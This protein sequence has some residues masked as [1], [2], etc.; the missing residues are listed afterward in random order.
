MEV[1]S[2]GV[3]L[4]PEG[5]SEGSVYKRIIAEGP[6]DDKPHFYDE[7]LIHYTGRIVGQEEPFDSSVER[8]SPFK[9]QLGAGE[10]L[11]LSIGFGSPSSLIV[12]EISTSSSSLL[13]HVV[14]V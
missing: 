4:S 3:D 5:E 7:V 12:N 10:N 6:K 13:P 8:G 14:S 1:T 9:F 2:L 11:T